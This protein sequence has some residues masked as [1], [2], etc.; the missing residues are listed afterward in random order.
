MSET[1]YRYTFAE[2][3]PPEEIEDT[4]ILAVLA[5]E[6]LHGESQVRLDAEHTVERAT[7]SVMIDAAT[8]VGQ[9]LNRLFTGLIVREFGAGSFHVHR[10]PTSV[11]V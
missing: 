9:D 6:A 1:T 8:R 2:G 4:L 11:P 10:V 3:V 5:A 7:R